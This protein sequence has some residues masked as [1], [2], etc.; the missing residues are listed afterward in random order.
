[1][2]QKE[3]LYVLVGINIRT[4]RREKGMSQEM[5]AAKAK[6]ARTSL[7]N[8]EAG[9]QRLGLDTLLRIA[10]ELEC[11][12]NDLLPKISKGLLVDAET[13]LWKRAIKKALILVQ[14]DLEHPPQP[15]QPPPDPW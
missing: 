12:W 9:K 15:P 5:L 1:M 8:I 2:S 14:R 3:V 7:T 4:L 6:I 10:S 13:D 11:D